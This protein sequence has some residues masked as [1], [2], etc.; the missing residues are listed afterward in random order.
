VYSGAGPH[1]RNR[2]WGLIRVGHIPANALAI[3]AALI[4][5]GCGDDDESDTTSTTVPS[6]GA[7]VPFDPSSPETGAPSPKPPSTP[8]ASTPKSQSEPKR[9]PAYRDSRD[10]CAV[11]GPAQ[12]QKEYGGSNPAEAAQAYAEQ[13]YQ[14]QFQQDAFEGC[15]DGFQ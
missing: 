12:V 14:P 4:I 15:L 9:S 11:F 10:L 7:T 2:L 3:A 13:S 1:H 5:V 6:A 8:P